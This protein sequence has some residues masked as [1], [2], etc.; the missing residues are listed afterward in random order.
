MGKHSPDSDL[1][2]SK[3]S[4]TYWKNAA[5]VFCRACGA[6]TA[7]LKFRYMAVAKVWATLADETDSVLKSK[8]GNST[9]EH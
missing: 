5:G 2:R 9:E 7:N 4:A 1:S 3:R 6:D 8:S